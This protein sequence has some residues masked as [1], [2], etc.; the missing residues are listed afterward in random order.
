MV[1]GMLDKLVGLI[2]STKV[3]AKFKITTSTVGAV[4]FYVLASLAPL[5]L[6]INQQPNSNTVP[7]PAIQQD[8]CVTDDNHLLLTAT[9]TD[10]SFI[11]CLLLVRSWRLN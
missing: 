11:L 1:C 5:F 2:Q 3:R 6:S 10:C 7:T 4:G 8:S 9:I